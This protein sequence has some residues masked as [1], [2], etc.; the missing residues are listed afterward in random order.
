MAVDI[1][2]WSDKYQDEGL[3]FS[4]PEHLTPNISQNGVV[5]FDGNEAEIAAV[6][7]PSPDILKGYPLRA[8]PN[9][10]VLTE[11]L[12]P[13]LIDLLSQRDLQWADLQG[14]VYLRAPGLL[15]RTGRRPELTRTPSIP[16][17]RQQPVSLFSPTRSQVICMLLADPSLWRES[18][19][20]LATVSGVSIGTVQKTMALLDSSIYGRGNHPD[21]L[22]DAFAASFAGGM[23]RNL[24]LFSGAGEP[25]DT[26]EG[27][28]LSGERAVNPLVRGGNTFSAYTRKPEAVPE[29]IFRSKWRKDLNTPNIFIRRAFWPEDYPFPTADSV[30]KPP[31]EKQLAPWPLIYAE[32]LAGLDPRLVEV[33]GTV[34][35]WILAI[36]K[37]WA[38]AGSEYD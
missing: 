30:R 27:M 6:Y 26:P 10:V 9:L 17:R 29:L 28:W 12:G 31:G 16:R 3:S 19:R 22:L 35:E 13:R 36:R 32:L 24:L 20:T 18:V 37:D 1:A 14:N 4:F 33:A 34:K 5:G 8:E 7:V 15:V 38:R 21:Q 11:K 23:G 25:I 2:K